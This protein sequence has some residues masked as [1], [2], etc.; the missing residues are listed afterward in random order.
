MFVPQNKL[1]GIRM[2]IY[3]G[4]QKSFQNQLEMVLIFIYLWTLSQTISDIIPID[5]IG[6]KL[7][8]ESILATSL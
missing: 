6:F 1:W 7:I 3:S 4:D 8:L 2:A 5:F